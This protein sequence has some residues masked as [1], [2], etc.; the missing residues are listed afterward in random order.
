MGTPNKPWGIRLLFNEADFN[1]LISVVEQHTRADLAIQFE[2]G[3]QG[4]L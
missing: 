4:K 1:G 2:K 3:R